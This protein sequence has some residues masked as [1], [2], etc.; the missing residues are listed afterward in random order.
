MVSFDSRLSGRQMCL[1]PSMIK[2]RGSSSNDIEIC[3]SNSRPLP[4]K[5]NRQI[6]KILEDL[7]INDEVFIGLQQTAVQNLQQSTISAMNA[8]DF[9]QSSLSDSATGLPRLLQRLMAAL[10]V[11]VTEDSF[12][13]EIL[14][15]LIQVQ[16]R[17]IKYRSRIPV[18]DAVTLY[19]VCD[20][21]GL[22][23]ERE[24]YVNFATESDSYVLEGRVAITR[25]PALHPGDIQVVNAVDVP[26]DSPLSLLT[27]CV[28]FSQKGPRD[29]PSMLSGGD[30]DGDLY[31]IIYRD[32]MIP[33]RTDAPADYARARAIDIGRSVT[34]NDMAEFFID[35]ME[36]DQLGRIATLHQIFADIDPEGTRSAI[37]LKLATLH[38]TAVD[39]SKTG[40]PVRKTIRHL[41]SRADRFRFLHVR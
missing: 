41:S 18:K 26:N 35:F 24:V 23:G 7:G 30:L 13:R 27:N 28:V 16:L 9:I 19:G 8:V 3:G 5:L 14:G 10:D 29:L 33:V 39:F 4:F 2:F 38:S 1:R 11:D 21:T 36:N 15:A 20:F 17:E 31:N 37:C 12:L 32:D 25:S 40:I 22:L 34:A 6:I